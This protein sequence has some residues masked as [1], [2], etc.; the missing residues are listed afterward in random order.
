V[1]MWVLLKKGIPKAIKDRII[2]DAK[3]IGEKCCYD[4]D[5]AEK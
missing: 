1:D 4:S 3:S 5:Q 2:S